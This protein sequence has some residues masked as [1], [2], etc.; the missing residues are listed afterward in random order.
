MDGAEPPLVFNGQLRQFV[1][2]HDHFT[3]KV[4]ILGH[5]PSIGAVQFMEILF[6][7]NKA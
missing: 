7:C 1:P 5:F 6:I 3:Q 2:K 4:T